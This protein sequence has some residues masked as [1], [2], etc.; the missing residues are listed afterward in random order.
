M[1]AAAFLGSVPQS[2]WQRPARS[3]CAGVARVPWAALGE[4]AT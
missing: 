2:S 4:A 3:A 1:T